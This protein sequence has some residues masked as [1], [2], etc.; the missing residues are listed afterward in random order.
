MSEQHVLVDYLGLSFKDYSYF[1]KLVEKLSLPLSDFKE[2]NSKKNYEFC[3]TFA[4][5]VYL[6]YSTSEELPNG[7]NT[8]CYIELTGQGCRMVE[9][10]NKNFDWFDF[11]HG[12]HDELTM[13]SP[14]YHDVWGDHFP[15]RLSR[16]DIACDLLDDDEITFELMHEYTKDNKFVTKAKRKHITG[17]WN[18]SYN[19]M[20]TLYFGNR[21]ARS[22]RLF[23]IYDKAIEQNLPPNV[24]WIRFEFELRNDCATSF[25]LNLCQMNG[26]WAKTYYAVLYNYLRFTRE[27]ADTTKDYTRLAT[28]D[29]WERFC[30][31]LFSLP[32]L[33]LPG[34]EY[35]CATLCNYVHIN[36]PSSLKAYA[37]YNEGDL[38]ELMEKLEQCKLNQRQIVA[39]K[40][41]GITIEKKRP[42]DSV[43][44]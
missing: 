32:Q 40:K 14:K 2:V 42:S 27:P 15:A 7:I 10:W 9:E 13:R 5:C 11:L 31:T 22:E 36:L 3:V 44:L 6:H 43:S 20:E 37:L 35:T 38:S 18:Y 29:W 16:L 21:A 17:I 23:R 39:L 8:G 41:A 25:Y 4:N 1:E 19:R 24:R 34:I 12:F 26:N 33:Y 30:H 28:A